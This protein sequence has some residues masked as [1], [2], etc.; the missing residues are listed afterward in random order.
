MNFSWDW[1]IERL[2][3]FFHSHATFSISILA[4][5]VA[6]TGQTTRKPERSEA[7]KTRLYRPLFLYIALRSYFLFLSQFAYHKIAFLNIK[8]TI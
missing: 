6:L 8:F 7:L 1:I 4:D 5:C 3:G 2:K